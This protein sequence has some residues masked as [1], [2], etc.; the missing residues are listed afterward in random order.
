MK[1]FIEQHYFNL[2]VFMQDALCSV[3]GLYLYRQRYGG[4]WQRYYSRLLESEKYDLNKL[5]ELQGKLVCNLLKDACQY[6][7]YYR[8]NLVNYNIVAV[9]EWQEALKELPLLDKAVVRRNSEQFVSDFYDRTKLIKLNTSGTTGTPLTV[10]V[11]PEARQLNYAFFARSKKWAGVEGRHIKSGTFAG[12]TIVSPNQKKPPFWRKNFI[13]NN[14]LFS[15]YHLSESNLGTY[16]EKLIKLQPVFIDSYP[17]SIAV[18][19]EYCLNNHITSIRPRAVITSAETLFAHQ[20]EKIENAFGCM[21]FDQ[22]GCTE[23]AVFAS[24]CA[25]GQYHVNPEYGLLEV[26][27]KIGNVVPDGTV[28]EFV[29][30]GFTN[31]AMPLIRYKIGDMGALSTKKCECGLNF[32]VIEKI[33]G[34]ADDALITPDGRLVGRLDPVFKGVASSIKE[35]QIVQQSRELIRIK[36]VQDS[37]YQPEHGDYIVK[38]LVKR[39]GNDIQFQIEF[40]DEIPRTKSGKFRAVVNGMKSAGT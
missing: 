6:V 33:V 7:P 16:V 9:E 3:Y 27:D 13:A 39:M 12:R 17:S 32:P 25:A 15:S 34:R 31:K 4:A 30:T 35:T 23:Q 29:C 19:A 22:Y 36:I 18:V 21:V 37:G 26:V 24:Q 10:Y 1:K 20:R 40:V 5:T 38:E 11:A 28:G 8:E 2:P 14:T